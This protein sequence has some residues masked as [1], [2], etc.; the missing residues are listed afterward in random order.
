M[1]WKRS[2][3]L[4]LIA[5]HML[6]AERPVF[7]TSALLSSLS[8]TRCHV[9]ET[10][11]SLVLI[12]VH[13]LLAERP[14]FETSALLSSLSCTRCHVLELETFWTLDVHVLRSCSNTGPWSRDWSAYCSL[15]ACIY[16]VMIRSLAERLIRKSL[17]ICM[18]IHGR[19]QVPSRQTY[20]QIAR[21]LL[22][23]PLSWAG[24]W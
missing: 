24:P 11:L 22:T 9:L 10:F 16:M 21:Y 19:D 17:A 13:M 4:V 15:L 12:V 14:V 6:L 18:H 5:M 7:K 2:L 8:C 23:Y 1:Y 3:S 20:R